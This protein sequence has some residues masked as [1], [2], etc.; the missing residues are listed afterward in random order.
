MKLDTS[1]LIL[2]NRLVFLPS[3]TQVYRDGWEWWASVELGRRLL[4]ILLTVSLPQHMVN[5]IID[6]Y[7]LSM[8]TK[9]M[10]FFPNVLQGIILL[11]LA[12][13]TTVHGYIQPYRV[14][15]T[16]L[17]EL[18]VNVNFCMLLLIVTT[19]YFYDDLFIFPSH[20]EDTECSG[21]H[22]SIAQVIWILMPV[23]YLPLLGASVTAT[24]LT[25]CSFR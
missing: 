20:T 9:E 24:V 3:L 19:P 22:N 15:L 6:C 5:L 25:I 4:L 17:L 8:Y 7:L 18:A 14:R 23:Y 13:Y 1:F 12:V 2:Q 21:I 11:V 16:N 10:C